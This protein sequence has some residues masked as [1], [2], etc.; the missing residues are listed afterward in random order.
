[1]ET[2]VSVRS[3]LRVGWSVHGAAV[4]GSPAG[5]LV[6][7]RR[8]E[9]QPHASVCPQRTFHTPMFHAGWKH[10]LPTCLITDSN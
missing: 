7:K 6:E 8:T 4:T 5:R 10:P 9:R 2:G 1:M 3:T